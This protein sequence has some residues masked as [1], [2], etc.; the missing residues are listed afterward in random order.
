[1]SAPVPEVAAWL[2]RRF[3]SGSSIEMLLGDLTEEH[4]AGR[5]RVWFWWQAL[6]GIVV[7]FFAEEEQAM[8]R[9]LLYVLVP[10]VVCAAI[11]AAVTPVY[12]PT[13]YQSDTALLIVPQ[14]VPESY[15]RSTATTRIEDRLL[16]LRQQITSR[17]RLERMITDFNLY[18]T[19]RKA[20]AMADVVENM[21]RH[22]SIQVVGRDGFRIS[23]Q[24]DNPRA[25]M[26]VTER[27]AALFIEE[28]LRDRAVQAVGTTQFLDAQ[29]WS[30]R[31]QIIEKESELRSMRANAGAQPI[32]DADLLPYEVLKETYKTL[33]IKRQEAMISANLERRQIGEQFKLLEPARLPERAIGP[34]RTAV[35]MAGAG[36]GLGLGCIGIIARRKKPLPQPEH[37]SSDNTLDAR[38]TAGSGQS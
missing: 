28:N 26:R 36:L 10:T 6:T 30:T 23:F 12:L 29:I 27:L 25:V 4:Q 7:T 37:H 15:V 2:L 3:G 5:S 20:G 18:E 8:R 14:R 32:S 19:E 16:S 38:C 11:T 9:R 13:R 24:G 17:T 22:I 31:Q 34:S 21:R 33:L 1:V 35:N